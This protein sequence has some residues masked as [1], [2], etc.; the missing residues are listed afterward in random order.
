MVLIRKNISIAEISYDEEINLLHIRLLDNELDFNKSVAEEMLAAVT[1]ITNG[2][3]AY[4]Y[5][6]PSES[7]ALPDKEAEV[8]VSN[9]SGIIAEAI[10]IKHLPQRIYGNFFIKLVKKRAGFPVKL[11]SNKEKALAWLFSH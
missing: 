6:D 11:F 3:K 1:E 8:I 10:L 2:R 4:L 9:Y 5:F 7:F